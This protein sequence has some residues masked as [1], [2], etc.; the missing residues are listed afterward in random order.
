MNLSSDH[1]NAIVQLIKAEVPEVQVVYVFGSYAAGQENEQSDLDIA[2]L[3][4]ATLSGLDLYNV[5]QTIAAKLKKDV[6]VIQLKE[7]SIVL[8]N[9]VVQGGEP[10][11]AEEDFD[12]PYYE[13]LTIS[14]FLDFQETTRALREDI[15]KRGYVR[16]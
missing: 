3:A 12:R 2:F 14:S 5:R 8:R 15:Q 6:D 10:I 1:I 9:E 4:E 13:M 11:Y 7:A 16:K